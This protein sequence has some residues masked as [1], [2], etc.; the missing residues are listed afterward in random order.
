[1]GRHANGRRLNLVA[2]ASIGLIILLDLV[3][4]GSTVLGALRLIP[5]GV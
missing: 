5:A 1:M 2:G 3:M 4:L